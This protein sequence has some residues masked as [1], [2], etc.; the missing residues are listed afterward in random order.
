MPGETPSPWDQLTDAGRQPPA[1]GDDSGADAAVCDALARAERD[2]GSPSELAASLEGLAEL[3]YRQRDFTAAEALFRCALTLRDEA[4][5][6]AEDGAL[7]TLDSLADLCA[8][9]GEYDEAEAFLR[10]GLAAVDRPGG[11]RDALTTRLSVLAD[12]EVERGNPAAAE[13]LLLRLLTLKQE[14]SPDGPEVA[15]VLTRLA[16]VRS[17]LGGHE[18]AEHLLWQALVATGPDEGSGS[19]TDEAA[20]KGGG[21]E[22]AVHSGGPEREVP[23]PVTPAALP[24]SPTQ[25]ADQADTP[26]GQAAQPLPAAA[27]EP[28][29]AGSTLDLGSALW[30]DLFPPVAD[31]PSSDPEARSADG[32][33]LFAA[34]AALALGTFE[35]PKRPK[36]QSP[37]PPREQPREPPRDARREVPPEVPREQ[38]REPVR[39]PVRDPVREVPRE[40][41][42]D[43][44]IVREVVRESR[45]PSPPAERP[46]AMPRVLESS[47]Q[48]RAP[49]P[50]QGP[51]LSSAPERREPAIFPSPE[52][53]LLTPL[54]QLLGRT[55]AGPGATAENGP[56][57]D[58]ARR[59]PLAD[60]GPHPSGQRPPRV[61]R[62]AYDGR[63]RR[64]VWRARV[65]TA[66]ATVATMAAMAAAALLAGRLVVNS[67]NDRPA[68]AAA[69]PPELDLESDPFTDLLPQ[70]SRG[71]ADGSRRSAQGSGR[72]ANGTARRS[73]STNSVTPRAM[74]GTVRDFGSRQTAV[75]VETRALGDTAR[76]ISDSSAV[77]FPGIGVHKDTL[78]PANRRTR[79]LKPPRE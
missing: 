24:A 6:A 58:P 38:P 52:P 13:P 7:P 60:D 3:K 71:A 68:P 14:A 23:A 21:V 44:P 33:R 50:V 11:D 17:A 25:V 37:E 40:S 5:G 22:P 69:A 43:V 26:T 41:V 48:P 45:P 67:R 35:P 75:K 78:P 51:G 53:Q 36:E 46:P 19:Y 18:T 49:G 62:A 72:A 1:Q 12:F 27:V 16:T 64:R 54:E 20:A 29:H 66:V 32:A 42:R 4:G 79:H 28:P 70:A 31:A 59:I 10:R 57:T 39:E 61:V 2:D 74:P 76:A 30:S 34:A 47:P 77:T 55:P 15:G 65:T 56:T 8:A 63:A 9:R 73:D